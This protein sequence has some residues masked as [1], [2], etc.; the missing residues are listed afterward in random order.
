MAKLSPMAHCCLYLS[1]TAVLFLGYL[2][3]LAAFDPERLHI[4][5]PGEKEDIRVTK[6]WQSSGIAMFVPFYHSVLRP[7]R[8]RTT[9]HEVQRQR[10]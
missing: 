2:T 4:I 7:Y 9:F 6:A 3:Y 1:I 8:W 5:N 10:S